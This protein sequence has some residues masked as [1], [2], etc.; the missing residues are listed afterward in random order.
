MFLENLSNGHAYVLAKPWKSELGYRDFYP[1]DI[2]ELDILN[3][4][5]AHPFSYVDDPDGYNYYDISTRIG[6][7]IK[8]KKLGRK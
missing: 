5:L 6:S 7:F 4:K 8:L 3:D 2:S 1:S